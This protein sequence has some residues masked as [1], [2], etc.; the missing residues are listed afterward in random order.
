MTYGN[1]VTDDVTWP[2]KVK[3]VTP[4]HLEQLLIMH[5]GPTASVPKCL[6][7]EVSVHRILKQKRFDLSCA[8]WN[9]LCKIACQ[10]LNHSFSNFQRLCFY[11]F[12]IKTKFIF[13]N[14]IQVNNVINKHFTSIASILYVM[15]FNFDLFLVILVAYNGDD[16]RCWVRE[17]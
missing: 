4:M 14:T 9:Y 5:F 6:G 16:C 15:L 3:H 10:N 17:V 7:A 8:V 2:W 12:K 13:Y 11:H 1:H